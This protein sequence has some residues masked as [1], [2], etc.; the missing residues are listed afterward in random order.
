M[1][2]RLALTLSLGIVLSFGAYAVEKPKKIKK[3]TTLG[4]YLTAA[5]VHKK[6]TTNNKKVLFIDVRTRA[7][8]NFL[9]MPSQADAN[10]P[11]MV[12]PEFYSWNK[13]KH[14]FTLKP[15]NDFSNAV[16]KR[17]KAKGLD[18]NSEVILMC[19]SGSRSAK[20]VNLLAK[21]GYKNVYTVVDGY[22]GG[23]AKSGLT[24]GQRTV[25]GWKNSKLPWTYKL[26]AQKMYQVS[27][28]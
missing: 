2:S 25:D 16:E 15:N 20:A 21:L 10:I 11:Y 4:L 19:R 9:G 6:I 3:H 26:D 14:S 23:K 13:K 24:K 27:A 22:E 5:E 12:M 28:N 8:V 17:L 18:K 1:I 7:E